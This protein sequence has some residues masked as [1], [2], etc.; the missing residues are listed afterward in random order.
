MDRRNWLRSALT[1]VVGV[2]LGV[3]GLGRLG[4]TQA[5]SLYGRC[6][7]CSCPGY[8]GSGYTCSRGGCRH[9]YD[10]HY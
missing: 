1:R 4:R 2:V 10:R 3:A 5:A 8:Q 7:D 9:H 6:H